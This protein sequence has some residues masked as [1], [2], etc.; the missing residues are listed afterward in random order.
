MWDPSHQIDALAGVTGGRAYAHGEIEKAI[1]QAVSDSHSSYRVAYLP[2]AENWDGKRHRITVVS[3][4]KDIRILAPTWYF[5]D[6]LEDVVREWKP[7]IPDVAI[8]SPFDQS[9]IGVSVSSPE[10]TANAI[11]IRIRVDAADL[12]LLPRNGRYSRASL[13]LQALCYT[14]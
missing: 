1:T 8:T 12:M 14:P 5:A 11:R 4:R 2:P 13:A 9:D 7:P 10:K 6:L 3:T